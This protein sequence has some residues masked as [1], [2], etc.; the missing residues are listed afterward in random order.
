MGAETTIQMCTRIVALHRRYKTKNMTW[1]VH[2]KWHPIPGAMILE[3]D[4][5]NKDIQAQSKDDPEAIVSYGS[6][7][8]VI[9]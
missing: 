7:A 9:W 6:K 1:H 2:E 4:G 5:V 8:T 3:T